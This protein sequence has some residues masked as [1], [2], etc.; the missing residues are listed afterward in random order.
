MKESEQVRVTHNL[1][2]VKTQTSKK[3]KLP[4][5]THS[6]ENSDEGIGQESKE[7]KGR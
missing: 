3:S 7:R 1:E 2:G 5:G 4:R 6:L